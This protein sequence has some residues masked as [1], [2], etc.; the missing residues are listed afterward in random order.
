M[1]TTYIAHTLLESFSWFSL[2][3]FLMKYF[4]DLAVMKILTKLRQVSTTILFCITFTNRVRSKTWS[5]WQDKARMSYYVPL[6][7]KWPATIFESGISQK[8]S[9]PLK[10]SLT[11]LIFVIRWLW[12]GCFTHLSP[13]A[14][15]NHSNITVPNVNGV[16]Q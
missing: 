13:D 14:S 5:Y 9:N 16:S 6:L 12:L 10:I 3:H 15:V 1:Q 8:S 11:A 7:R 2:E 4:I